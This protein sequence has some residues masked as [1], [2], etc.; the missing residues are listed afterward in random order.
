MLIHGL[1]LE[2]DDINL[3]M[4]PEYFAVVKE[5]L[6]V[7][8]SPKFDYLWVTPKKVEIAVMEYRPEDVE[9]VRGFLVEKLERQL[10]WKKQHQRP[11]DARDIALIEEYLRQRRV[12]P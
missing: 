9:Y 4:T 3:K 10:A 12:Q 7:E 5:Q 2:T 8:R 1:R 11:K 6:E